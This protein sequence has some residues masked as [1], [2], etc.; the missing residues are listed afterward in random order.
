M[1]GLILALIVLV[2]LGALY[3]CCFWLP[4]WSFKKRYGKFV[5]MKGFL[6]LKD[7]QFVDLQKR[8]VAGLEDYE[9]PCPYTLPVKMEYLPC[10]IKKIMFRQLIYDVRDFFATFTVQ[11]LGE[12]DVILVNEIYGLVVKSLSEFNH[13]PYLHEKVTMQG[14]CK[15]P[16]D[17]DDYV[18]FTWELL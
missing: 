11:E 9:F 12:R 17:Y 6:S 4:L 1:N 16:F 7:G 13:S 10:V 15:L 14:Q 8:P 5:G 3:I 18:R 2:V